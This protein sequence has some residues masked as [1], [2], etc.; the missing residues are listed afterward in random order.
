VAKLCFRR[1][2][3]TSEPIDPKRSRKLSD[4]GAISNKTGPQPGLTERQLRLKVNGYQSK[5]NLGEK[6]P[7]QNQIKKEKIMRTGI[8]LIVKRAK[9][10]RHAQE[11]L[12]AS[13]TWNEAT[14]EQWDK[15]IADVQGMQKICSSAR[16]MR[17]SARAALDASLQ[18]IHR[19][20]IQFLAMAKFH[21]RD[22]PSKLEAINRLKCDG[23]GRGGIAKEAMDIETAWQE[24]GPEWAPTEL[25]TFAS[26]QALR[27][28][29]IELDAAYIATYST[30]RTQ[31]ELLSQ[32][33]AALNDANVA[34]YA[35]ATRIFPAGTAEGE[36]IRR[37]IPIRC[38]PTVPAEPPPAQS[39]AVAAN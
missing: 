3:M 7:F 19:C 28:Q 38:S 16:F 12:K 21:F 20:T 30:W 31:S 13:W 25:N 5:P 32:K 9:T 23:T 15:E 22:D 27:K 26:F 24:V 8:D 36:M 29:C 2:I 37:S 39:Q 17:N 6:P 11:D 34:W 33:S 18:E 35:A 14:L 1:Q 4:T 10:T